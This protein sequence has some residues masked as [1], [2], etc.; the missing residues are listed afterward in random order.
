MAV[1][2]SSVVVAIFDVKY[3]FHLQVRIVLFRRPR[4]FGTNAFASSQLIP[5]VSRDHQVKN[6]LVINWV[7]NPYVLM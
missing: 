3:N 1:A 7:L 6:S 2:V 4:F 5:H